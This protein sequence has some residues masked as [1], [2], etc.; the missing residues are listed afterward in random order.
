M[1]P[2][3]ILL[4]LEGI[5]VFFGILA[6]VTFFLVYLLFFKGEGRGYEKEENGHLIISQ[7]SEHSLFQKLFNL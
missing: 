1:K 7:C 2:V 5:V 4:S 6:S 3:S